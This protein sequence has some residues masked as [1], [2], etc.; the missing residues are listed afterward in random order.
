MTLQHLPSSAQMGPQLRA[1]VE[2]Q[3]LADLREYD[4]DSSA[5]R[6][7]WSNACGEGHC[8][9]AFDGNLESLSD[10]FVI[11]DEGQVLAEGWM[12]F[13]HGGGDNPLFVFWLFLRIRK[14][15]RWRQVKSQPNI[16]EHVWERLPDST[17]SLCTN[18][19]DYDA[20]WCNDPLVQRWRD[21]NPGI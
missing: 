5:L 15:K 13:I 4:L 17:R 3:L 12:D 14:G 9:Q 7:D 16:P 18:E 19:D 10:V 20:R 2:A 11:D 21:E 1:E 6:I 8:K